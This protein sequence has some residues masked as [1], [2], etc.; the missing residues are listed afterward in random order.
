MPRLFLLAVV[1]VGFCISSLGAAEP[2]SATIEVTLPPNAKLYLGDTLLRT[3]ASTH[4]LETPPLERDKTYAYTFRLVVQRDDKTQTM[5]RK[6]LVR[7]GEITRVDFNDDIITVRKPDLPKPQEVAADDEFKLTTMERDILDRTNAER[8]KKDLPEL[9]AN[10]KLI[11]AARKHTEN[12]ARQDKL[13]HELDGKKPIDRAK[14]GG[15]PGTFIG[16]NV[17]CGLM[18][19]EELVK[20][21]MNSEGHRKNILDPTYTEIGIG[22]AKAANGTVYYTQL[23]GKP[24]R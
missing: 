10:P 23:F 15:Y 19:A 5:T 16:E 9:K 21:W 12:M 4:R 7:A 14:D 17:A 11:A 24:G 6:V 13:A 22:V 3:E 2:T 1:I 8:K 18:S 20:G